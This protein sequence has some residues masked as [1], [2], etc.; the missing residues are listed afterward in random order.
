MI[1]ATSK[2]LLSFIK[3]SP[4]CF[5][6]IASIDHLPQDFKEKAREVLREGFV[7]VYESDGKRTGAYSSSQ[8]DLHP[9]ILLNYSSTLDD[10]FTV[11][12]EAGHSIHSLY[13]Q[14]AQPSALQNYTIFV[15]EIAST[16][17]EH[18]LLDYLMKHFQLYPQCLKI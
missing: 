4:S 6:A 12:H 10:V 13:A 3:N 14:E 18:V 1:N 16:F 5:H 15:A 11:A 7:D 9:F 17:N 2:N 8:P